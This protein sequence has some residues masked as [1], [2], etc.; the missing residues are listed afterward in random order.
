MPHEP[1]ACTI[2]DGIPRN[3]LSQVL[4]QSTKELRVMRVVRVGNQRFVWLCKQIDRP[5]PPR[6]K[7]SKSPNIYFGN[8]FSTVEA[9]CTPTSDGVGLPAKS[10]RISAKESPSEVSCTTETI[11][12]P[13][14]PMA[15]DL[16]LSVIKSESPQRLSL[17]AH[18]LPLALMHPD[19]KPRV[20]RR[21]ESASGVARDWAYN[22]DQL[23]FG[24][25]LFTLLAFPP[26]SV[27][28]LCPLRPDEREDDPT[29]RGP[30]DAACVHERCLRSC[31]VLRAPIAAAI[32]SFI[33][34]GL[35]KIGTQ[36]ASK[37]AGESAARFHGS[38]TPS[39]LLSEEDL[40]LLND[41]ILNQVGWRRGFV[42]TASFLTMPLPD[43]PHAPLEQLLG[44]RQD[45]LPPRLGLDYEEFV[46]RMHLD[47]FPSYYE[48]YGYTPAE[49]TVV[50]PFPRRYVW[51]DLIERPQDKWCYIVDRCL[52]SVEDAVQQLADHIYAFASKTRLQRINQRN[53]VECLSPL[54]DWKNLEIEYSKSWQ[55]A[56][57]QAYPDA[58]ANSTDDDDGEDYFGARE[59][60][61]W[62]APSAPASPLF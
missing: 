16:P 8:N 10:L 60:Q 43:S 62:M 38:T 31:C 59:R 27:C 40:V 50:S 12:R 20:R 57:W 11:A 58:F 13:R 56:L 35:A 15:S 24:T 14:R 33:T 55:L 17:D 3:A 44:P 47:V 52:Q 36:P 42:E 46:R 30:G 61:G 34:H 39:A 26:P 6:T 28:V 18:K 45:H 25:I 2:E 9:S 29:E 5:S 7:P 41:A 23:L 21:R 4:S 19:T 22:I 1:D 49:C 54:L 53:R 48:P 32:R 51:A 37:N